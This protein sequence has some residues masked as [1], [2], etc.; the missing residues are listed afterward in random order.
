MSATQSRLGSVGFH[1]RRTRSGEV[2][3]PG[4]LIVVF[5]FRLGTRP[6]ICFTRIS[7]A[8][9]LRPT[10]SPRRESIVWTRG[11]P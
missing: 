1:S 4:T 8:T 9:R 7:R 10:R 3:I 6:E 2:V 11:A 5:P